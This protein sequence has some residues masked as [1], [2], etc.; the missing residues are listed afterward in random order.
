MDDRTKDQRS[1]TDPTLSKKL[2]AADGRPWQSGLLKHLP[3]TGLLSLLAAL[4]CGIGAFLVANDFDDKPLDHWTI[5]AAVVQ[6]TVLLSVLATLSKACLGYAFTTGITIFWWKSAVTGTSLYQLHVSYQQSNSLQGILG[7]RPKLNSVA[8]ASVATLLL[9]A[10]GPLF[11]RALHVTTK[12]RHVDTVLTVP[13]SSS[14]LMT[15]STGLNMAGANM[16]AP[17]YSPPFAQTVQQYN[18]QDDIIL[19]SFGC[20]GS[21]VTDIVAAAWDIEC[22]KNASDY[23]LMSPAESAQEFGTHEA[24][25]SWTGTPDHQVMFSTNVTFTSA[26]NPITEGPYAAARDIVNYQIGFDTMYKA[27]EG[28]QGTMIRRT[29]TLSEATTQYRV[30]VKGK[31]VTLPDLPQIPVRALQKTWRHFEQSYGAFPT[32]IL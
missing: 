23:K 5:R 17:L 29:C 6:P 30:E 9:M 12:N 10:E 27:T 8:V 19:S 28:I 1:P 25:R 3:W 20:Q 4:L 14:L 2:D 16:L 7:T 24:N 32:P 21:C 15:G 18:S 22:S 13:I 26:N 11:Q 31:T